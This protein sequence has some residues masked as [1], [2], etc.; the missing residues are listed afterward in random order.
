[1]NNA[2]LI[3]GNALSIPIVDESVQC[4]VTSPPYY[5]L[6][7]YGTAKWEGGDPEC[8]H[9]VSGWND[10]LKPWVDR[11]ERDGEKRQYCLKCGAKRVDNQIGLEQSPED[12]V[13]NLVAVFREVRRVL[14][15]DG[16]VFL[17]LGDSY[18]GG[19]GQSAHGDAERHIARLAAG[20][21][22]NRP[23]QE[24]GKPGET[25]NKDGKHP[26]IKPKDLIGIPW[27]VAFALQEDGWWLRSDIIWCMSHSTRVYAKTQ[28][29]EMP[30]T[31]GEMVRLKP[32]TVKLW[33]G[34]KW[35]QVHGFSKSDEVV[36]IEIGLRNGQRISCTQGHVF[37]TTRGEIRADELMLGDNLIKV[38]LPEPNIPQQPNGIPDKFGW[39]I[40]F[41]LA[42]GSPLKGD[43]LQ[44]SMHS[45]E[46]TEADKLKEF[47]EYY[48]S[49]F[50]VFDY[51]NS[52]VVHILGGVAGAVIHEYISSGGCKHKHLTTAAWQRSNGF[53]RSLL[54]GYLDGDGYFDEANNRWR[55]SFARNDALSD[56]LRTIGAR[57]GISVR[58]KRAWHKN[59]TGKFYGWRGEIRF[60]N[61][62]R[63]SDTEIVGLQK[64]KS[65]RFYDIE[66]DDP[67]IFALSCGVLT[68]NSK[69]NPMPE[70]V[71]DRPTRSHEYVFLLT[72]SAKYYYDYEAILEPAAYDGR[73][74][75]HY[76][77]GDKD[78]NCG[79]HE[80]WP[81]KIRGFKE[82]DPLEG[83]QQQQHHG[84]DI[85]YHEKDGVRARNKRTVWNVNTQ[86]FSGAKLLA[87]YVG[88]DGKPYK[89]SPDCP[90]HSHLARCRKSYTPV[91]DEQSTK[92]LNHNLDKDNCLA[93][94]PPT[95]PVSKKPH[96]RRDDTSDNSQTQKPQNI[97]DCKSGVAHPVSIL[98]AQIDFHT[99]RKLELSDSLD[100]RKD[101]VDQPCSRIAI[102][103]SN[104]KSKMGHV[105]ETNP[106]CIPYAEN[107]SRTDDIPIQ[108]DFYA[109]ENCISENSICED[110]VSNEK[111]IDPSDHIDD[112]SI[113]KSEPFDNNSIKKCTC[114]IVTI[115][116]FAVMPEKLVEPC[117]L[118]GSKEGDIILDPF[119]GSG[120]V[121]KVALK[122]GRRF[123]GIDLNPKYLE[124]AKERINEVVLPMFE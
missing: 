14:R 83:L 103:H 32:E 117:I 97:D 121:G 77:G 115:D 50:T 63:T 51:G 56:D 31:I 25:L 98:P 7:D 59:Q 89:A 68:H 34:E 53:I 122:Y 3:H 123:V 40:G 94:S 60:D 18:W 42:E 120:T 67:H 20:K 108:L 54:E 81:N 118:A 49:V 99:N 16:I 110:C 106:S 43:G 76:K 96:I 37:P 71:K 74:D 87:D 13:A 22:I 47:A 57:L 61:E 80:R 52:R 62:R 4:V 44:F 64:S 112:H 39:V 82:K 1:M 100:C 6:R 12:Y 91:Y 5:G 75:T 114:Q 21:T 30:M 66:I 8:D 24:I 113:H 95:L 69:N 58:L 72:K 19:K 15:D 33:S 88:V 46:N 45:N 29:G 102:D 107:F 55:L 86:A 70:S 36:G 78:M 27:R 35:V 101:Y 2:I 41:Y 104:Q 90:F 26:V 23:Y 111:E 92:N 38:M 10:N 105:S 116:H 9:T 65:E 73:K 84:N 93:S 79:A 17:N 109:T 48:G 119:A 85:S 124:L 11:P 28:K